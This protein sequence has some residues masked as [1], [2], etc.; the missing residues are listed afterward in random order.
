[1]LWGVW[2]C[3]LVFDAF[4]IQ[5][6]NECTSCV[7]APTIAAKDFDVMTSLSF[8]AQDVG[9]QVTCDIIFVLQALD[10]DLSRLVVNEGNKV[11]KTF[12]RPCWQLTAHISKDTSQN[13]V[14]ARV[15]LF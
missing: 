11:F 14:S 12:V 9:L 13:R 8:R 4:P 10:R 3:E 5:P 15:G 6:L 2:C 7:L 1:M